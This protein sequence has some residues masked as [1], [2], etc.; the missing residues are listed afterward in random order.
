MFEQTQ[1]FQRAQVRGQLAQW[2]EEREVIGAYVVTLADLDSTE[3]EVRKSGTVPG[4]SPEQFRKI[5]V[6]A[7]SENAPSW[8]CRPEG[9]GFSLRVADRLFG[10]CVIFPWSDIVPIGKWERD[11]MGL[12]VKLGPLYLPRTETSATLGQLADAIPE[13]SGNPSEDTAHKLH[14]ERSSSRVE[15]PIQAGLAQHLM[16]DHMPVF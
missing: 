8:A 5:L 3:F 13:R 16:L 2:E 10:F 12:A 9:H 15:V 11:A 1:N 4:F 7:E 14:W 6:Q